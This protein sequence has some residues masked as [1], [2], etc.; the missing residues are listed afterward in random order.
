MKEMDIGELS[1]EIDMGSDIFILDVREEEELVY[2]TIKGHVCIPMSRLH[3]EFDKV[4]K[5][6]KVVCYCRSGERSKMA[7]EFLEE[8]GV[9]ETFNL[10]GGILSWR[11][12]DPD[13]RYY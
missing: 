3:E 1:E 5:D 9:K 12:I 4:P 8:K 2:G 6:K 11:A 10:T 13:V 7:A